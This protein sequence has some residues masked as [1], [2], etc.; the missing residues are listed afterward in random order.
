MEF[1]CM[2]VYTVYMYVYKQITIELCKFNL[3]QKGVYRN[4]YVAEF[5][6]EL[7]NSLMKP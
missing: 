6:D 2:C 5:D 7:K 3:D 1:K 4:I